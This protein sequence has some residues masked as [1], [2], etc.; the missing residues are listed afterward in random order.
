VRK[1]LAAI[2]FIA[3]LVAGRTV[4]AQTSITGANLA[5]NSLGTQSPTL[6]ATGYLGTYL[7]VPAG[8]ATVNFDVNATGGSSPSQMD[9]VIANSNFSFNINGTSASNYDTQ[10]VTLPAGTYFV[11]AQRDYD[12]GQNQS[13]TVNN[14]SVNTVSGS[15]ATFA[16]D[17]GNTAAAATDATNAATTYIDNYREGAMNLQVLG[18]PAGTPVQ[19]KET[20]SAFYWGTEVPDNLSTYL[21]NSTY[22]SLLKQNFNSVTPENA[23]KWSESETTSQLDNLDSLTNFASENDIRVRGHNLVWGSQQPTDVNNDFTNAR[24]TNPTTAAAGKAAITTAITNRINTY[25]GGKNSLDGATRATQYAE[26]D[27][28]NEDYHTGAAASTSTGDNYWKVMGG[29]TAAGGASWTAGLY[30]QVAAEVSSVGANTKLFTN[31]YNVL[32]NNS[33]QYG[34]FYLQNIESI[35][36]AGGAISGI[37]TE[38]YNTPGVGTDGSE[39]DPARAYATWQNLAAEGLP[40]E[41]T[42]FGET[43]VSGANEATGLTTAMTLA[44]GTPQMTGF[45]LWG[46]YAEPNMYAG[47]AGSVLYDSNYNITPA[48]QAYESLMSSWTTNETGM[49]GA[50]GAVSLPSDAFFGSYDAVINGQTYPFTFNASTDSYVIDVPE[51]AN[52][53]MLAVLLLVLWRSERSRRSRLESIPT[54][55]IA[56]TISNPSR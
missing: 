34:D 2:T 56:P 12:N 20:N 21:N 37:G 28:Y 9:V 33:D 45:T 39:V 5:Y 13:F 30:N 35:R 54:A 1:L 51:P 47:S 36:S 8:G 27:V 15:A 55:A 43:A 52:F 6:S 32:N 24:S 11:E 7:T 44:F 46:F 22:T 10:N 38:W 29:G 26:L 19:L 18:A 50:G 40:I 31:E 3:F 23:G 17:A 16:N 49:V 4:S 42:E 41:V 48:G 25:L 53:A 14:L